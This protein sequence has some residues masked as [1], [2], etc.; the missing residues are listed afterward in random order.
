MSDGGRMVSGSFADV[1]E[2]VGHHV[3]CVY[4][5]PDKDHAVNA[6]VECEDCG[7]VIVD[8]EREEEASQ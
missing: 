8:F 7:V 5:G 6:A 4:Y 3:V 2:H 1:L